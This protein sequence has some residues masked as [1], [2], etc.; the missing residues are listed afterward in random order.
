MSSKIIVVGAVN[1]HLRAA[2]T[3]L[4]KQHT[5]LNF[6]CAIIVG[7][8]FG[9]CSTEKELDEISALLNGNINVP[10][11]TYFTLGDRP[12]PTRIV[13]K[14][15]ADDEV[16]PNLYFLGKR[17]TLKTAEGVR[18]AALGGN[19]EDAQSSKQPQSNAVGRFQS[20]YGEADARALFGTHSADILITNQWPKGIRTGSN[21]PIPEDQKFLPAEIQCVADVCATL[22]PRYH[23]SVSDNF[24]FEREPFFH[25][26]T[27]DTSDG[28]PVTRF[29]SLAPFDSKQKAMYAFQ[30][31]IEIPPSSR[32][33]AGVTAS[34]LSAPQAKRKGLPPQRESFQRFS[35]HDDSRY[36][37]GPHKRMRERAP[38]PGPDR[39]FFCLS[40]PNVAT[41]LITSI[42]NES[43]LT[44]AKGPLPPAKFFPSLGFPG[45]MLIIPFTHTPTFGSISDPATRASTFD[46]MQRY[47]FALNQMVATRSEGKLG[48]VTWEVSRASGIHTH[49]QFLPVPI[50]LISDGLVEA[51][52]TVEAQNLQYPPFSRAKA[53]LNSENEATDYF[54]VSIWNATDSTDGDSE[55]PEKK[56]A[57]TEKT[58]ILELT[59]DF[60]FDL[61]FGR[62]VMAKLLELDSRMNWKDAPQSVEEEE[63]DAE[64]FKEAFKSYDFSME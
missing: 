29:I 5:K 58:L 17:G 22:K 23:F 64:A 54:R 12:L 42:G 45:H 44:T 36:R 40:N 59:P 61:Q 52:F 10:L 53:E 11:P 1:C 28:K 32:I 8:L 49:W 9:D 30:P 41:H 60:R 62:R 47:R 37:Q 46:E 27:D 63:A 31:N 26:P 55:S 39:C 7:N 14:I 20:T 13:E 25:M 18:I 51:A 57:G 33:D 50:A 16:C 15:E 4:A 34:P 24:F 43:Y 3:K 6:A 48:A 21:A 2:F 56:S 35:H 38:P 19:F